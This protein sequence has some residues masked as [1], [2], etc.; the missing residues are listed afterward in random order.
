MQKFSLLT[1]VLLLLLH[2]APSA[3]QK[4]ES[5]QPGRDAWVLSQNVFD[6]VL[7]IT[8]SR[9]FAGAISSIRFRGKEFIDTLDNGRELQ[10]A[11]SFDQMGECF[12]PTEAG[13][14]DDR[15]KK[16]SSVLQNIAIQ[17]NALTST[18]QMAF[19]SAPKTRYK[20]PNARGKDYCGARPDLS[21]TQNQTVLSNHILHKTVSIGVAGLANVIDYK[22]QYDVPEYHHHAT[23]EA[24]S[25]HLP[26]D[27]SQVET[28]DLASGKLIASPGKGEQD[29]PVILSTE[30]GQ[31]ALGVYSPLLP[32]NKVGYGRFVFPTTSKWNCVFREQNITPGSYRF[33][34]MAVIGTREEVRKSIF[35][36]AKRVTR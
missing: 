3:A 26:R 34:C 8:A 27:F 19:W 35:E 28:L 5:A 14:N 13:S 15:G 11:S 30:D 33:R 24:L 4:P 29:K 36:L 6:S 18:V 12:N 10:S 25:A 31:Y 2:T 17:N 9:R 22:V 20:K 7:E 16:S 32:Q 1:T 21:H 23:F